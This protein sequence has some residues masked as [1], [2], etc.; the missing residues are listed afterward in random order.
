MKQFPS[1]ITAHE[2][3][4][5]EKAEGVLRKELAKE[6]E[7]H[8]IAEEKLSTTE[9]VFDQAS[10]AYMALYY[11]LGWRGGSYRNDVKPEEFDKSVGYEPGWSL[12]YLGKAVSTIDLSEKGEIS[13][14]DD[15][16]GY[17]EFLTRI[18]RMV[19][20]ENIFFKRII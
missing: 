16:D 5:W 7:S 9:E 10:N 20:R 6:W 19:R 8:R 13:S 4:E 17:G 14:D 2:K 3:Q 11:R 18:Q 15:K 1:Y 12:R